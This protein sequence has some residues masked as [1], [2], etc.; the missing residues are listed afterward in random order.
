MPVIMEY[1]TP[2][3]SVIIPAFNAGKYISQSIQSVLDQ[4]FSDLI[5]ILVVDDAS[6]DN[7]ENTVL[8][9]A[10]EALNG[11]YCRENRFLLYCKNEKNSGVAKTRNFGVQKARGKYIAFLDADDWWDKEK[12]EKQISILEQTESSFC[13]SGRELMDPTGHSLQKVIHVP[14]KVSFSSM[15]KTNYVTCSSVIV[16]RELALAFPMEHDEFAEDYICWMR[17][18]QKMGPAVG[19][20]EPLVKY[21]MVAGS[22]SNDKMKAA[23][24][25][26]HS[27]RIIGLCPARAAFS[28]VSY[29]FNGIKKYS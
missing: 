21:R 4:T 16:K 5:E 18:L 9:M 26:Y 15:L 25:H 22:K 10:R 1:R 23:S 7:T 2:I 14:E 17:I 20:D 11:T 28:M 12:I 8:A 6:T 13:F 27:L 3:I 24:D 19:V 29:A